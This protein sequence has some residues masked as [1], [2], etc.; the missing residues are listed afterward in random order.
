MSHKGRLCSYTKSKKI[1]SMAECYAAMG[2]IRKFNS[3]L[4][5]IGEASSTSRG[6]SVADVGG[7]TRIYWNPTD[8]YVVDS[9]SHTICISECT[10]AKRRLTS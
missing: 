5:W 3:R 7:Y 4:T 9:D 6:C 1:E 2:Q 8:D 10:S